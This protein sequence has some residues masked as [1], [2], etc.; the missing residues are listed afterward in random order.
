M[1]QLPQQFL[2]F[3]DKFFEV[4]PEYSQDDVRLIDWLDIQITIYFIK[5]HLRYH[6]KF[7]C[8]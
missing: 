8:I 4:F 6:L 5:G 3:L 1:T 2:L 7:R